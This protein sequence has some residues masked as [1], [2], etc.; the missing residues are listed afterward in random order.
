MMRSIHRLNIISVSLIIFTLIGLFTWSWF[1]EISGAVIAPGNLVVK[2][3]V[4]QIQHAEGGIVK[5][6]VAKNGDL[7][8]AGD[9]LVILDTTATKAKLENLQNQL[10]QLYGK[11]LRLQAE[12]DKRDH[13]ETGQ[14]YQD[15]KYRVTTPTLNRQKHIFAVRRL[16]RANQKQQLQEQILQFHNEI[17]GLEA[18]KKAQEQELK[19]IIKELAG[20]EKLHLKGF[21][22]TPR[23]NELKR[24]RIRLFGQIGASKASI[25]K[26]KG[27]ISERKIMLTKADN[28]FLSEV[29]EEID[30]IHSEIKKLSEQEI[31]A[32]DILRRQNLRSPIT[33]YVH[34][35][36]IH[37]IGS[38]I[39][40]GA[41]VAYIVPEKDPLIVKARV[42]P[43]DID[44]LSLKQNVRI[45]LASFNQKSTSEILGQVTRISPDLTQDDE[46]KSFYYSVRVKFL[47]TELKR[48]KSLPLVPGMPVETFI[49]TQDR[50]VLSFLLKPLN[51]GLMRA[52]REE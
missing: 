17:S 20:M 11:L 18:Q 29:L 33:G 13:F 27:H 48:I 19:I 37:T 35:L 10:D 4:R 8:R 14:K 16:H 47:E 30:E 21:A 23:L 34:Q 26:L 44:Q 28:D 36:D 12:R 22:R 32:L 31:T 39:N 46:T 9:P 7:V 41:T 1:T 51:D 50:S 40:K 24:N 42:S 15:F 3:N 49:T 45:R 25:A 2:S 6:I 38:V 52:F 43:Y 5:Q